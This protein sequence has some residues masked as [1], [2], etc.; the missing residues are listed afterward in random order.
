[1]NSICRRKDP[2]S[3]PE[4]FGKALEHF[5]ILE[6][7]AWLSYKQRSERLSFWRSQSGFEV[8]I[9][10]EDQVAIEIKSTQLVSDKHLKGLRALCEEFPKMRMLVVS[11][12][13]SPRKTSDGIEIWPVSYFLNELWGNRVLRS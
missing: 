12:D 4:A 2:S 3:S 8:D 6:V 9:L 11:R 5:I 13:E 10:L 1:V 7:R